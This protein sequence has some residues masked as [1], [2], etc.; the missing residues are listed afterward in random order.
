MVECQYFAEKLRSET[1]FSAA[2]TILKP[3]IPGGGEMPFHPSGAMTN[4]IAGVPHVAKDSA[5][6]IGKTLISLYR[7]GR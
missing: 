7:I 6:Q 1:Q 5:A 4:P 2:K 3:S